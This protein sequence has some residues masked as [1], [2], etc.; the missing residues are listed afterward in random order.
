MAPEFIER[1][2]A[3]AVDYDLP[4]LLPHEFAQYAADVNVHG[5]DESLAAAVKSRLG[6]QAVGDR[7][8]MGLTYK[9]E[10]PGDAFEGIVE[11]L[12]PGLTFLSLHC[13]ASGDVEAVHP[14]D[15]AWRVAEYELVGSG[16]LA[17][18]LRMS[19]VE[20]ISMPQAA[21]G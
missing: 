19:G 14:N 12:Q 21:A 9:E 11:R 4:V 1:T 17:E 3:I 20:M 5:V 16:A 6:P 2:A 7:F 10:N 8:V 18:Q 15:G 13:A